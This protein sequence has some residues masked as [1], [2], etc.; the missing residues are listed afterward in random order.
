M[1]EPVNGRFVI[2]SKFGRFA[3]YGLL[4]W[5]GEVVFTG[6]HDFIRSRDARLPSRTS[7]WMFPIYGLMAPLYE[8]VHESLR[9]RPILVRGVAYGAGF[10]AVEYTS[11]LLLRKLLGDAP[12]D[13]S[14][15]RR[16][17]NGLIRPDYFP[18]WAAAGLAMERVHDVLTGRTP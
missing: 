9:D 12:W 15:A 10:L 1:E 4:G 17:V 11:G 14:Y 16:H 6:I 2:Q 8:P 18:L 7:I 5:C 13:Y 3:A